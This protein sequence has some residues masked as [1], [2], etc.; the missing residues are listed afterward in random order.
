MWAVVAQQ[1]RGAEKEGD[2]GTRLDNAN[3]ML[4]ALRS[5]DKFSGGALKCLRDYER[6]KVE[7]G[8]VG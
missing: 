6:D 8:V 7:V 5:L 1:G 2:N 4:G 3:L